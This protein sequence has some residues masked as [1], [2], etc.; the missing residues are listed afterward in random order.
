[1]GR[2][3]IG[4]D[5]Y[6]FCIPL[7]VDTAQAV[8]EALAEWS[9]AAR[10]FEV[11]LD[12]LTDVT[13]A[14]VVRWAEAYPGRLVF[15]Y[16]RRPGEVVVSPE[17]ARREMWRALSSATSLV[18]LD[19]ERDTAEIEFV[20]QLGGGI[21]GIVSYHDFTRTPSL[22]ELRRR[23]ADLGAVWPGAVVKIATWCASA[24]DAEVLI[25]LGRELAA[26]GTPGFIVVGMG[27]VGRAA[28]IANA[29]VGNVMNFVP[30][31]AA[32]ASAPGQIPLAE[33]RAILGQETEG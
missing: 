29:R 6:P 3:V 18:D 20:R 5:R 9:Y 14:R 11:W 7:V 10:F 21:R 12:Y 23:V 32:R 30:L 33:M 16:R 13:V 17:G 19:A 27:A 2:A 1:M 26:R 8:E 24:E 4:I 28:R 15:L 22:G 31:D 25:E